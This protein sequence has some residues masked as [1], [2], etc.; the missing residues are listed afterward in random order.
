[1][2]KYEHLTGKQFD[3][4]KSDCYSIV[5]YFYKDN[6]NIILP[7][8]ARPNDFWEYGMDMYMERFYKNNFYVLNCHP[9][10]YQIGDVFLMAIQSSVVNHAA[11]LIENGTILHH[12]VG[13][14]ST[15]SPYRSIWRNNTMAVVRHRDVK[16]DDVVEKINILDTLP[17]NLRRKINEQ[18]ERDSSST[19]R[20][21]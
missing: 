19:A 20:I 7:N 1:M 18:L 17:E 12:L 11:V 9:S 21:V 2:I 16:N 10:E 6:Y 4:G 15:T 8:Y 3:F 13:Q 5:R 14:I